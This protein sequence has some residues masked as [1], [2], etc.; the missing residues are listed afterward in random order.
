M[1]V[2]RYVCKP[3]RV[4]VRVEGVVLCSR[5]ACGICLEAV[6]DCWKGQ[7]Q[8]QT[9]IMNL[10]TYYHIRTWYIVIYD[11]YEQRA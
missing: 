11:G 10:L 5:S 3:V 9:V 2:C 8:C 7:L 1:Y 6:G 4:R